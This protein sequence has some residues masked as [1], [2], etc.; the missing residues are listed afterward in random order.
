MRR[1]ASDSL[2]VIDDHGL[3]GGSLG[4]VVNTVLIALEVLNA[5]VRSAEAVPRSICMCYGLCASTVALVGPRV[6]MGLV[7][8]V[9]TSQSVVF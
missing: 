3:G 4:L 1:I 8:L 6:T 9:L 2:P 5:W 7:G